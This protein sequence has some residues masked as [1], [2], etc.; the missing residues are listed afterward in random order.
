M[1]TTA[2]TSTPDTSTAARTP[3]RD[4]GRRS[5][6]SRYLALARAELTILLRNKVATFYA[7]AMAPLLVLMFSVLPQVEM[8]AAAMGGN[9]TVFLTAGVIVFGLAVA[10]YYNLTTAVVARREK[11][12]L[13]RLI[14]GE[15]THGQVLAAVATPNVAI[16][17]VQVVL[18]LVVGAI[19]FGAPDFTNPLLVIV[20]LVLAVPFFVLISFVTGAYTRTVEAA[21]LTTM[22]FMMAGMLLSGAILPVAIMP[23]ALISVLEF[24]PIYPV[25]EL[26]TLGL[27]GSDGQG[28]TM[29]FAET[30]GAAA[31]PAVVML[32][33][34]A[35]MVVV[36]RRTMRWEPRR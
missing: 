25:T 23:E 11:L 36:L 5:G 7:V 14:A 24:T 26:V 27:A 3:T 34:N 9:L 28:G 2:T 16:M 1:K 29:G 35:I 31:R 12:V 30:F 17:L 19:A 10:V 13:K 18:V 33:W 15:S 32:A 4:T 6:L 21:Q 22:P 20:A 8:I